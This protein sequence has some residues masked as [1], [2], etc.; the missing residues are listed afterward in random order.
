MDGMESADGNTLMMFEPHLIIRCGVIVQN[1]TAKALT[2]V[3]FEETHTCTN[4]R[5][6]VWCL[7]QLKG[8]PFNSF[9]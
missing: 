5:V 3:I 4:V 1:Q 9:V 7:S 8:E 6:S 2:K